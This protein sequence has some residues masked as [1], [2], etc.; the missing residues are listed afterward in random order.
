MSYYINELR[1]L[2]LAG[3]LSALAMTGAWAA[4]VNCNKCVGT[5]DIAKGAVNASRLKAGA[6]RNGKIADDAVTG[7][8][9][10]DGSVTAADLAAG[11][12]TADDIY[13]RTLVVSPFG[14]GSNTTSNGQE[15]LDAIT[16]LGSVVPAPSATNPWLIRIEPGIYDVGTTSVQ[17]LDFVDIA[18]SGINTTT[19]LG[20]TEITIP[21][22][23]LATGGVVRGASDAEIRN[24]TVEHDGGA[25][26]SGTIVSVGTGFMITDVRSTV[27]SAPVSSAYGII[28]DST[29]A[30]LTNVVA[31]T[32]FTPD[33]SVPVFVSNPGT[34]TL[35]NVDSR[36]GGATTASA[37]AGL[38]TGNAI[39]ARN[40]I[41][42]GE[43]FGV[44]VNNVQSTVVSSQLNAPNPGSQVNGGTLR[45]VGTYDGSLNELDSACQPLP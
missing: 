38:W 31:T 22:S 3:A 32:P 8:K 39:A 2:A 13:A 21:G 9:I 1:T 37:S 36:S 26:I 33:F 16:F 28:I 23:G 10:L 4:D 30:V 15:L 27:S 29:G 34:A 20:S 19:I 45:C 11:A 12:V 44:R 42:E 14:D 43:D 5:S 24:L 35:V 40:S 25:N 41:F 7:V 17:M 18:G 6:V